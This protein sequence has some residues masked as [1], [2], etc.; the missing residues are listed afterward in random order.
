MTHANSAAHDSRHSPLAGIRILDM[1]TVVA[2]PFSSTLC[3]D[4]GA[5][6]VKL[7]LPDGT[8]PLRG[9]AP[10]KG[11]LSLYWKV[12]N[13]G[14]RGITL[15]VRKPAGRELFLKMLPEFDVLV[16]NF[17]TGTLERWG[18]DLATLHAVNPRLTV[19]RL[20]GFGQTGPYAARAGF[21]RI[22]E[23]MSGFTNLAGEPAGSPLHM[24]YPVGDMVA[25]LFGAFAIASAMA[26]RR[27]PGCADMPGR[28]IDLS[29]TEA[30]FRLLEPL[31]VE[32]EQLGVVR[33]RAGNRAT[34]T[35]P[36][37]MY[38]TADGQWVSLVASSDPI[39]RRLC[40]AIGQPQMA[41]EP[42]FG[43]NPDRTRNLEALDDAIAGWFAANTYDEVARALAASEIPFS[44]IFTIADIVDDPHFQARGAIVR[45]PDPE[46]GSIPAPCTV[47]R[48]SGY[49]PAPPRSGPGV[50]EHNREVYGALGLTP[51]DIAA[52]REQRVL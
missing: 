36:S 32:Y 3:A 2:A 22:F 15:D 51:A 27:R 50:G 37:N 33:Q 38:A 46:L 14:K 44:K 12:T 13:R 45:L 19:L 9:L 49:Q 41:D 25:G 52:L 17:R 34:Y 29:A 20:T 6:V 40:Q 28:E 7:E 47:P 31:A 8:D 18:L 11:E 5:D 39:F 24:N 26:E 16:E 42:R 35:A 4:M 48:F 43:T 30:L 21:A 23:A 1:A 10:V